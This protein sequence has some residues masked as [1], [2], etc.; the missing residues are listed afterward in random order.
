MASWKPEVFV[1]GKWSANG[2]RFAT[3][4]EAETN[5]KDLFTRWFACE[6]SRA[7]ES[8]DAPNY[9]YHNHVLVDLLKNDSQGS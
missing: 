6:G 8:E 2:L 3:K 7:T 5:A 1:D 4:E 9:S